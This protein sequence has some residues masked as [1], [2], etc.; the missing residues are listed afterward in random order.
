MVGVNMELLRLYFQ[1]VSKINIEFKTLMKSG[2]YES[3]VCD[4]MNMSNTIFPSHYIHIKPQFQSSGECDFIDTVSG[5]KFD[6]KFP[7]S[8]K[9]GKMIGS[10]NGDVNFLTKSIYSEALEFQKCFSP[11]QQLKVHELQLYKKFKS[12]IEDSTD[13]ENIIFFIPF[14]IVYDFEGFPLV[15]CSDI[16]K[17]IFKELE[18][19]E[20]IGGK[21]LYAVYCSI[22]KKMVLR[23]LR[24]DKREYISYPKIEE[25]VKYDVKA[26]EI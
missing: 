4:L 15:G 25:Y 24:T 14:P 21:T 1:M 13:D 19:S 7:I 17:K 16:L 11:T 3:I 20:V 18:S 6:V 5:E 12:H 9:Q 10:R 8:K 26:I 23:N 2:N 22:D